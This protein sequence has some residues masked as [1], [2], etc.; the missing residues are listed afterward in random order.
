[1]SRHPYKLVLSRFLLIFR[2]HFVLVAIHTVCLCQSS[3]Q[4]HASIISVSLV[5]PALFN[6][7]IQYHSNP[8]FTT[9]FIGGYPTLLNSN[10][11]PA[12]GTAVPLMRWRLTQHCI[13]SQREVR[14]RA[15]QDCIGSQRKK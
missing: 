10:N 5:Q 8:V 3:D 9:R 4:H 11:S 15:T 13:N 7:G 1:M 14:W 6:L 2:V 12:L